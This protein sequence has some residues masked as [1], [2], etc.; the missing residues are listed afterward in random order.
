MN[1]IVPC[2]LHH[3]AR[4]SRH[5]KLRQ[6]S[7]AQAAHRRP[8]NLAATAQDGLGMPCWQADDAGGCAICGHE[9]N[10]RS[11]R[12]GLS[13][14]PHDQPPKH[15]SRIR[16][17]ACRLRMRRTA[18]ILSARPVC[19][20]G[21]TVTSHSTVLAA[22]SVCP[23][24]LRDLGNGQALRR[25]TRSRLQARRSRQIRRGRHYQSLRAHG[26]RAFPFACCQ[27][28]I[29]RRAHHWH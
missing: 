8:V 10:A 12:Q 16:V 20:Y 28:E 23:V 9:R 5:R 6:V 18:T 1:E 3:A 7:R 22:Q 4:R 2:K 17:S 27:K 25:H 19:V 15:V 11:L 29:D 21:L 13:A 24:Q 14:G 26:I